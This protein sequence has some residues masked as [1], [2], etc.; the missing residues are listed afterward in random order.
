MS[1]QLV[2]MKIC[3][4]EQIILLFVNI[5]FYFLVTSTQLNTFF[6]SLEFYASGRKIEAVKSVHNYQDIFQKF[7]PRY[8]WIAESCDEGGEVGDD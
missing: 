4:C 8:R 7:K 6:Y 3:S 1:I 2:Y 5:K